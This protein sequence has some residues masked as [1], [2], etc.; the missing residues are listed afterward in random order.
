MNNTETINLINPITYDT[1][2]DQVLKYA[3]EGKTS[4]DIQDEYRIHA[5]SL[6]A[7][8][9]KRIDKTVT[10]RSDISAKVK[11]I[12]TPQDWFVITEAWCGDSAQCVP[13]IKKAADENPELINLV[14]IYRDENPE[15]MNDNLSDGKMAIPKL[16]IFDKIS[17]NKLGNWGSRP[18]KIAESVK[19]LKQSNPDIPK[20]EFNLQLH[21][22]YAENKSAAMQDDLNELLI[23]L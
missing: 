15:F 12:V 4:G 1:Y 5:T 11:S 2:K 16:V 6:N 10:I 17:G 9:M 22:W 7:Q 14:L 20:S 19:E 8:R 21:S 18:L 13:V 23:N 3:A